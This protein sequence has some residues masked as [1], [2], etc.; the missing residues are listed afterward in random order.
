MVKKERSRVGPVQMDNCRALLG[1]GRRDR[2]PNAWIRDS[3]W[4][5]V[6]NLSLGGPQKRWTDNVKDCLRKRGLDFRQTRRMVQDRCLFF[7]FLLWFNLHLRPS[8]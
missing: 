1:I 6:G 8:G 3:I 7:L 2:V 5:S 4:D